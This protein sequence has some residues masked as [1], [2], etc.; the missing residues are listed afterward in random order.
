MKDNFNSALTQVLRHEGL[1]SDHSADPGGA[2]MKGVTLATYR[3][4]RP[5]ATKA[6]LR[7]ITDDEVRQIYREGYWN[8]IRGDDLPYGIDLV[9]FDAAVNSGPKR[10]A[11]WVQ[12][13]LGV[14]ADGQ[15][16]AKT[17][18]AAH[19]ADP[20][21]VIMRACQ[22]RMRFLQSLPT[23]PKFGKGWTRRVSDVQEVALAMTK[24]AKIITIP[25]TA[26]P[27]GDNGW[28]VPLLAAIADFIT[29]I[30]GRK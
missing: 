14:T 29:K 24:P 13:A 27:T 1:W 6:Q 30:M 28:F 12:S 20:M 25:A 7:A 26:K 19:Q 9:A 18:L 15:I 17:I 8:V 2:T 4:H 10:G 23:W 3:Q 11:R 16:G 21:P 5:G 22:D